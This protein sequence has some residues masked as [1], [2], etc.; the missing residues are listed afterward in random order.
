MIEEQKNSMSIN[1]LKVGQCY[2]IKN[3]GE[4]TSFMVLE[5]VG[6]EDFRIKDLLSL[7][8]YQLSDLLKYGRGND[9]ELNEL[10]C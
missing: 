4:S 9:F 1:N 8:V 5:M 7:E 3:H 2:F 6:E 10:D